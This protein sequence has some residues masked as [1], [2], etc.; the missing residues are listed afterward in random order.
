MLTMN[1]LQV[2]P[3]QTIA[4]S[5]FLLFFFLHMTRH[6]RVESSNLMSKA[7]LT[8]RDQFY[9]TIRLFHLTIRK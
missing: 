5:F 4:S 9:I 6:K 8:C 7:K 2:L 3:Y 1:Q